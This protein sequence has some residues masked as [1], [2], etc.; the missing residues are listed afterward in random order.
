MNKVVIPLGLSA[1]GLVL[2]TSGAWLMNAI[3]GYERDY[4]WVYFGGL[5]LFIVI[6]SLFGVVRAAIRNNRDR[7]N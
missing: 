4:F 3:D 1:F 2:A 7:H 5:V 6:P